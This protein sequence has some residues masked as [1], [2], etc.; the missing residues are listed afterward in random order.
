M[1]ELLNSIGKSINEKLNPFMDAMRNYITN[2]TTR[3]IFYQNIRDQITQ[4]LLEFQQILDRE[5][6]SEK[7]SKIELDKLQTIIED[8]DNILTDSF[9]KEIK[10]LNLKPKSS[11]SI[12]DN[13]K[14]ELEA[15][16]DNLHES[17]KEN[18]DDNNINQEK[19]M[20][21]DSITQVNY[22]GNYLDPSM[23]SIPVPIPEEYMTASIRLNHQDNFS[24]P[25][26]T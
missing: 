22:N 26:Q 25:Q 5:Y 18:N 15:N 20:N 7:K 16:N 23:S 11:N 19:K 21:N 24:S 2:L 4:S 1:N 3:N 9:E 17:P 10:E 6:S 13:S 8:L 12:N 14:N